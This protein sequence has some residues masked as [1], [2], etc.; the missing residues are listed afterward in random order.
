MTSLSCLH[1]KSSVI[2]HHSSLLLQ[3]KCV[4]PAGQMLSLLCEDEA[5]ATYPFC[6]QTQAF[7]HVW[8]CLFWVSFCTGLSYVAVTCKLLSCECCGCK[9][10]VALLTISI[11]PVY[12]CCLSILH[13][14]VNGV[15]VPLSVSLY[16]SSLIC[17]L[18][19]S[20]LFCL[21]L[22]LCLNTSTFHP[23]YSMSLDLHPVFTLKIHKFFIYMDAFVTEAS[24]TILHIY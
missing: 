5:K 6:R 8:K 13:V 20:S 7:M 21:C 17:H 2:P 24:G 9:H 16:L 19:L 1:L 18:V 14:W 12:Q 4:F 22:P 10:C 15:Q 23:T 3:P 11:K